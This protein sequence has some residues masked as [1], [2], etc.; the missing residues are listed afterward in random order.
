M[1]ITVT[2]Q[3]APTLTA[4]AL[5]PGCSMAE[6]GQ[7]VHYWFPAPPRTWALDLPT[8]LSCDPLPGLQV[9]GSSRTKQ[10]MAM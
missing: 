1:S 3:H 10:S 7:R 8:Y 9:A 4:P 2:L 6:Q 5:Q